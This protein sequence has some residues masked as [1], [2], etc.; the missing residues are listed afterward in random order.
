MINSRE[1]N[2]IRKTI[3]FEVWFIFL[4]DSNQFLA[5]YPAQT[6]KSSLMANVVTTKIEAHPFSSL[7]C[8]RDTTWSAISGHCTHMPHTIFV[9]RSSRCQSNFSIS[10]FLFYFKRVQA[11]NPC[12]YA[13]NVL[14]MPIIAFLQHKVLE[15]NRLLTKHTFMIWEMF[16]L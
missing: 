4:I 6:G 15:S 10:F 11:N 14:H 8:L 5:S 2:F 7:Q 12:A 1:G 9:H 3:Q 13:Q 16:L